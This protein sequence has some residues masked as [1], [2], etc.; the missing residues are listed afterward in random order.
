MYTREIGEFPI[1]LTESIVDVIS[2]S[3][4]VKI[5]WCCKTR[6]SAFVQIEFSPPIFYIAPELCWYYAASNARPQQRPYTQRDQSILLLPSLSYF[7]FLFLYSSGKANNKRNEV[8]SA[9]TKATF[10]YKKRIEFSVV[11]QNERNQNDNNNNVRS[12]DTHQTTNDMAFI[13]YLSVQPRGTAIYK[14]SII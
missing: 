12:T 13:Y 7:L 6:Y 8:C 11:L 10:V 2:N 9:H 14:Y 1:R 5:I 3:R 4:S